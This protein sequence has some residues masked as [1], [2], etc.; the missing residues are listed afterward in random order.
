MQT[1][2]EEKKHLNLIM[3]YSIFKL[4]YKGV[5][6]KHKYLNMPLEQCKSYYEEVLSLTREIKD[7]FPSLY[8]L[9]PPTSKP[10]VA[11]IFGWIIKKELY[12]E[13]IDIDTKWWKYSIFVQVELLVG[14]N[15]N[16]VDVKDRY[17]MI[18]RNAIPS[19]FQHF[20]PGNTLC[21]HFEPQLRDYDNKVISILESAYYLVREYKKLEIMGEFN[22]DSYPHGS[23]TALEEYKKERNKY[24]K[25]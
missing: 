4:N 2:I 3:N 14:F 22:V 12:D 6:Y 1:S 10:S 15:L 16:G 19:K 21:T 24:G 9:I 17:N 25:R 8:L 20:K 5:S 13:L 18:N 23:K 11:V 7:V